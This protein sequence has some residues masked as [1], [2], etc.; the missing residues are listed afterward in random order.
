MSDA[1]QQLAEMRSLID[2]Y[3]FL[4]RTQ[5]EKITALERQLEEANHQLTASL[6]NARRLE[7]LLAG[8]WGAKG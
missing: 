7:G 5:G 8:T 4:A 2:E 6:E 1:Q 3:R